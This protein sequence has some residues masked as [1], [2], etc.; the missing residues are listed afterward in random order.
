MIIQ[1]I[2]FGDNVVTSLSSAFNSANPFMVNIKVCLYWP[3][4]ELVAVTLV[5]HLD[6][7]PMKTERKSP[8]LPLLSTYCTLPGKDGLVSAGEPAFSLVPGHADPPWP[9]LSSQHGGWAVM[10]R[11][12]GV[13]WGGCSCRAQAHS[14]SPICQGPA[15]LGLLCCHPGHT[16]AI[17][18]LPWPEAVCSLS[19]P[20]SSP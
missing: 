4:S 12:L 8:R 19:I 1:W 5:I 2:W 6:D 20:L 10:S 14:H 7:V 18:D 16:L 9:P 15:C 17:S 11:G 13:L 3:D